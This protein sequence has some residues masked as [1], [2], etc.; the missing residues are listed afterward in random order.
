MSEA[1]ARVYQCSY[2]TTRRTFVDD[3]SSISR[4]HEQWV[5]KAQRNISS[6]CCMASKRQNAKSAKRLR[7]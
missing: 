1:L 4:G 7:S 2:A 5:L 3:I 6:T